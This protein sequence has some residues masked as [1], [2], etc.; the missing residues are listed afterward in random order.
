MTLPGHLE[1]FEPQEPLI[2]IFIGTS[3]GDDLSQVY[4]ADVYAAVKGY[5]T[6]TWEPSEANNKLILARNR[7]RVLGAFRAKRWVPDPSGNGRRGFVGEP[8]ELSI[9]LHYVGKRVPNMYRGRGNP[10]RYICWE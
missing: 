9:Q 2:L 1:D 5:W 6:G 3:I 4:P 8:A 10:I 7:E